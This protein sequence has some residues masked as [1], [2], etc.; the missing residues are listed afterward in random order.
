M[1][2]SRPHGPTNIKYDKSVFRTSDIVNHL[3]FN[4][5]AW[6]VVNDKGNIITV[7]VRKIMHFYNINGPPV[8]LSTKIIRILSGLAKELGAKVERK[9]GKHYYFVFSKEALAN[10]HKIIEYVSYIKALEMAKEVMA[11]EG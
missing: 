11:H 7:S 8:F 2:D 5:L 10:H 1:K 9:K 3:V 4:Y 6:R